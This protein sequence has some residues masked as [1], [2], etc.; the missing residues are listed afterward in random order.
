MNS[1]WLIILFAVVTLFGAITVPPML[2]KSMGMRDQNAYRRTGFWRIETLNIA[3]NTPLVFTLLCASI[4]GGWA[5][6]VAAGW[7]LITLI[8]GLLLLPLLNHGFDGFDTQR[9]EKSWL[10]RLTHSLFLI[11]SL[12][13]LI[14]IIVGL[15]IGFPAAGGA[16]VLFV[17]LMAF[18]RYNGALSGLLLS[19]GLIICAIIS[20]M[21]TP[22]LL[23]EPWLIRLIL[24]SLA[25][26]SLFSISENRSLKTSISLLGGL[27]VMILLGVF[28][29]SGL[30]HT[31]ELTA[32]IPAS[33]SE[34]QALPLICL[35]LL[36]PGLLPGVNRTQK[37]G[38]NFSTVG[39]TLTSSH[40]LFYVASMLVAVS[41]IAMSGPLADSSLAPASD[42]I[43]GPV[44]SGSLYLDSLAPEQLVVD[45]IKQML[46]TLT[47]NDAFNDTFTPALKFV[48][49]LSLLLNVLQLT[50]KQLHTLLGLRR[51]TAA[52]D[53]ADN[54]PTS[55]VTPWLIS[56]IILVATLHAPNL[57]LWLACSGSFAALLVLEVC[58]QATRL[59]ENRPAARIYLALALSMVMG[60]ALQFLYLAV[61]TG[62]EKY[63]VITGTTVLV[64]T[65]FTLQIAPELRKVISKLK[66]TQSSALDDFKK[67]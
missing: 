11:A 61:T 46:T 33:D 48:V 45:L 12:S 42:K 32:L 5:W 20:S 58:T 1:M 54:R 53:K 57:G 59:S 62:L 49:I 21:L 43:V 39:S 44:L 50:I 10:Y 8:M 2:H 64:F 35:V 63:Y 51:A 26:A 25:V 67:P 17:V 65:L 19:V 9:S 6:G 30:L 15:L 16:A 13:I 36:L 34:R 47:A 38:A 27:G 66:K 56:G 14:K 37:S 23:G 4:V 29:V 40:L 7:L 22:S 55:R 24:G 60:V 3:G 41:I 28:I 18:N 31:T 52:D